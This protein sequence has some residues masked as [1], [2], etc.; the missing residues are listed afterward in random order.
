[1]NVFKFF[2]LTFML[3]ILL[4]S[5]VSCGVDKYLIMP[6]RPL[7]E[8]VAIEREVKG[9]YNLEF[10][11][12]GHYEIYKG[13]GSPDNID[14]T[15][16]V[17]ETEG[18][19]LALPAY[20]ENQRVFFGIVSANGDVTIS[21]ERKI[22]L[23]G[24]PNFRDLGGLPTKDGRIVEWGKIYRSSKF[25]DLSKKDVE[26]FDN[27]GIEAVCDLRN[28]I[29]V[30][31][32]P[33]KLPDGVDYYR[34]PIGD[35]EGAT[36]K[37]LKKKILGGELKGEKAKVYFTNLMHM[38]ADSVALDFKPVMDM[39]KEGNEVPLVYHCSGGKDRTG[40]LSGLLL[41]ALG[42]EKEVIRDDYL[43]SNYYRYPANRSGMKKARL[44]GIDNETLLYAFEVQDEYFDAMFE[45]I[46]KEYGGIEPYLKEKFGY[47][48]Q[49]IQL[50]RDR[51]TVDPNV[52][53]QNYIRAQAEE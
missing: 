6:E 25:S 51:Y 1:M 15:Q 28:D 42:V 49:D 37:A 35:A 52:H 4:L 2:A 12:P 14:W 8:E 38:M 17:A 19:A 46:D 21:S 34:F 18:T 26:Y 31:K 10:E 41:A 30:K 23:K 13:I 27:L 45:V 11:A 48:E 20:E 44:L 36:Y 53:Y 7:E 32:D 33:N 5:C 29:E 50:L 3:S 22:P 24:T 39:L 9:G 43:L 16:P 47:T 40:L